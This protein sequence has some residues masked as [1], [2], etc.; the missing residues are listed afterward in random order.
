[1]WVS[2]EEILAL[3]TIQQFLEPSAPGLLGNKL[4]PLQSHLVP[5]VLLC[6]DR[7]ARNTASC[8]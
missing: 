7:I 2:Q 3:V 5:K 8:F 1:L 4:K 6:K